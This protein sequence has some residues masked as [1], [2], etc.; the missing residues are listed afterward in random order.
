MRML[1]ISVQT[2]S[3]ASRYCALHSGPPASKELPREQ[4]RSIQ[5]SETRIRQCRIKR[6]EIQCVW[7]SGGTMSDRSNDC[8]RINNME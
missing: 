2:A 1:R 4:G 7:E 3:N 5:N 6:D 8:P